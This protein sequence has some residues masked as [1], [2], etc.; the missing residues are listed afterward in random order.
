MR[1]HFLDLFDLA[2]Y[3]EASARLYMRMCH[4][5]AAL[6]PPRRLRALGYRP[7]TRNEQAELASVEALARF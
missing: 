6:P 2:G 3:Q 1:A 7:G 4:G 5:L